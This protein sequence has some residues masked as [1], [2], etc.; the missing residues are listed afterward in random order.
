MSEDVDDELDF[1]GAKLWDLPSV[2]DALAKQDKRTDVFDRPMHRW[3]FEPPEGQE[4]EAKPLTAEQIEEIRQAAYQEGLETGHAEG[5]AK[6]QEEGLEAGKKEGLASGQDEGYQAGLE[7]AKT[8]LEQTLTHLNGIISSLNAPFKKVNDELEKE[9]ALLAIS[10][11][12]AIVQQEVATNSNILIDAV[13]QGIGALPLN[14]K[15]YQIF[16]NDEDKSIISE[17]VTS[18]KGEQSDIDN[19]M[20]A[21][22]LISDDNI[23]R[24]GA[25]IVTQNNAVDMS[26]ERRTQQV[27][28]QVLQAKGIGND[29]RA[30]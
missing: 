11:A 20:Q 23:A 9:L 25:K 21:A 7:Q 3:Q 15:S 27:F 13:K 24:G 2:D 22:Q 26:I 12:K 14:E 1:S 19:I 6:G 4:E 8:E 10:L 29:P 17:Y 18:Y 16:I 30:N 28:A 5:F